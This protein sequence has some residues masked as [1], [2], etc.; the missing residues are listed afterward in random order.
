MGYRNKEIGWSQEAILLQEVLKQL[1][2]LAGLIGSG[3]GGGGCCTT[4]TI[5]PGDTTNSP[6]SAAVYAAFTTKQDNIILTTIGS[7]G[8]STLVGSTL[9]VPIYGGGGGVQ[10]I[11]PGT[12]ISINN[13]DPLNPIVSGIPATSAGVFDRVYLTGQVASIATPIGPNYDSIRNGKGSVSLVSLVVGGLNASTKVYIPNDIV[14]PAYPVAAT[15]P[16]GNYTGFLSVQASAIIGLKRFTIEV[17][18]CDNAGNIISSTGPVSGSSDPFY[19]G[20]NTITILDSGDINLGNGTV[21]QVGLSGYLANNISVSVGQRFR[22]HI[23]VARGAGGG[24]AQT[25]TV[26]IGSNANS[27]V[28]APVPIT[29]STVINLSNVPG[30][31]AT[32]A[33]NALT[34]WRGNWAAGTYQKNQQVLDGN[35]LTIANKTTSGRP[36][37]Q[38]IGDA[39]NIYTPITISSANT[40]ATQIIFGNRYTFN[41]NVELS[42]WRVNVIAG[43]SYS[44]YLVEDPLVTPVIKQIIN[45]KAQRSGWITL[46]VPKTII[47]TGSTY[48]LVAA[49]SQANVPPVI[50]S[51]NYNYKKPTNAV[52]P[53]TD[54]DF[55]QSN[56]LKNT[57]YITVID[58]N[59]INQSSLLASLAVGDIIVGDGTRW[60]IQSP[61]TNNGTYY[62]F[63]VSPA[64]QLTSTGVKTFTFEKTASASLTYPLAASYWSTNPPV[65]ITAQG[66]LAIN[67]SYFSITPNTTAYGTDLIIQDITLSPDWDIQA[68]N[69]ISDG[70]S[71]DNT[72]GYTVISPPTGSTLVQTT[73]EVV[74]KCDASAGTFTLNLPTAV[75]NNAKFIIKKTAGANPVIIDASGTETIDGGL[76]ATLNVLYTSINLVSDNT[77]WLIT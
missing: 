34:Q 51:A 50:S 17:F 14:G 46:N 37:P 48:D 21:T 31:T 70:S 20:K 64:T 30:S 33:L 49:V 68:I 23:S 47:K 52:L 53:P 3:G 40:T 72:G 7:S 54:G 59:A 24:G 29:T 74:V 60:A 19:T 41:K 25:M 22:F 4:Q 65:G 9:N 35:Y 10:S 45:Y 77:N 71:V 13:S 62:T 28:E 57:L 42:A 2:R 11:V 6:S 36:A 58:N 61:P 27:Y 56:N 8:P 38:L 5:S 18:L 26:N 44:I 43:N 1:E 76:T 39:S 12:N 67:T 55:L 63:I 15:L 75:N 32:D 73:G 69:G 66:L 16:L